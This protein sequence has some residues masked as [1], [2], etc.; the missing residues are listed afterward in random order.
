MRRLHWSWYG[1]ALALVALLSWRWTRSSPPPH[2]GAVVCDPEGA[3][4]LLRQ[5]R[6][7]M[8]TLSTILTA[9]GKGDARARS[10]AA[11][12]LVGAP[13]ITGCDLPGGWAEL[14]TQMQAA[15][16][17]LANPSAEAE[18]ISDALTRVSHACVACHD[19]HV[20]VVR[21]P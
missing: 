21:E 17:L 20:L 19:A 1:W 12:V 2:P 9:A 3:A 11:A 5:M 14:D 18:S 13:P 10:E 4:Q 16:P 15:W 6:A 7:R 8:A